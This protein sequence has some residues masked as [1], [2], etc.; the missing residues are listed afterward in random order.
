MRIFICVHTYA[1]KIV[2]DSYPF[3]ILVSLP[4]FVHGQPIDE[5]TKTMPPLQWKR[6]QNLMEQVTKI[7]KM[8]KNRTR[9]K[10]KRKIVF[11]NFSYYLAF[12]SSLMCKLLCKL[13]II[14]CC[15][16]IH[17]GFFLHIFSFVNPEWQ[18]KRIHPPQPIEDFVPPEF[19]PAK[20]VGNEKQKWKVLPINS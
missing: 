9:N 14:I 11:Q 16:F 13:L 1:Y 12:L 10:G 15:S 4:A 5:V 6:Q 2:F 7:Q 18:H 19:F 17:S 8:R 3:S 20:H